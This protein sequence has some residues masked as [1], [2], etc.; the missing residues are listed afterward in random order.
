MHAGVGHG[1][2]MGTYP[3][4]KRP[5]GRAFDRC[6]GG[7][8]VAALGGAVGLVILGIDDG[9]AG[10]VALGIVYAGTVVALVTNLFRT[11][12][13]DTRTLIAVGLAAGTAVLVLQGVFT[14]APLF[15]P[16]FLLWTAA[17]W[18]S[19]RETRPE[20]EEVVTAVLWAGG[21]TVIA[22]ALLGF[23]FPW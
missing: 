5:P 19:W 4:F 2:A 14:F 3:T 17:G 8:L 1:T 15:L 11:A 13:G 18:L 16:A 7:A 9:W 22:T 6:V 23:A 21:V 20:R 12:N 10:A